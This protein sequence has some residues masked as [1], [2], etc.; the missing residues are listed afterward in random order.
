[1]EQTRPN[2]F[3]WAF[4]RGSTIFFIPIFLYIS[5]LERFIEVPIL[6]VTKTEYLGFDIIRTGSEFV[7]S[8]FKFSKTLFLLLVV[9][10]IIKFV[11]YYWKFIMKDEN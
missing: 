9:F 3:K 7:V 1:M 2:F 4:L 11:I 10:V 8:W 5:L 6:E